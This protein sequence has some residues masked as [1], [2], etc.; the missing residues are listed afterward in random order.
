MLEEVARE[1]R[2]RNLPLSV[3]VID[4][5]HWPNQGR[6]VLRSRGLARSKR[7]GRRTARNGHCA[8]GVGVAN[9]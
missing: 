7:D 8:D 6:L 2:R 4:F 9:G 1:Y 3:M 5:F